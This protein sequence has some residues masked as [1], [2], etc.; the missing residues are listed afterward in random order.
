M[1]FYFIYHTIINRTFLTPTVYSETGGLYKGLD[2]KIHNVTAER[3][4]LYSNVNARDLS[5]QYFSDLSLWDTFRTHIPWQLLTA[6]EAATGQLRSIQEMT[7]QFG[8]FPKWPLGPSE[9]GCMIGLHGGAA[10]LEAHLKGYSSAFN[11]T[12]IQAALLKQATQPVEHNGR[13]DLD[14][15]LAEGF[16]S[17][18]ASEVAAAETLTYAFDDYVLAQLSKIVG[19]GVAFKQAELRSHNYRNLWSRSRS[20]MCPRSVSGKFECP[21]SST[22]LSAWPYFLEGDALQWTWFVPHDIPGLIAL[23]PTP[24]DFQSTLESFFE[25]HYGPHNKYGSLLPNPYYWAG[26]EVDMMTPWYFN[27]VDCRRT[28]YWTR[29]VVPMHFSNSPAGIPGNDDYGTMS[30]FL[31]F[32]ALGLYPLA[33]STRY[34]IGSP[35]VSKMSVALS[36]SP[37]HNQRLSDSGSI[38]EMIAYN[39]TEGNVYVE[40]LLINGIEYSDPFLEH[41]MLLGAKGRGASK[42]EFYMSSTPYS[43]L[44]SSYM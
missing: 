3:Q 1:L 9:S 22:G 28:Q 42:L 20:F 43:G 24:N 29:T 35:S 12:V 27:F 38:L 17:I 37:L 31:L 6:S 5:S 19:D 44:C 8:Y 36:S 30:A 16:V 4:S 2:G 40:K 7:Q 21:L 14:H 23:F 41:S 18:E 32:S 25:N 33:S 15:Y 11:V 39:N 34:F 10:M 26:N 13:N